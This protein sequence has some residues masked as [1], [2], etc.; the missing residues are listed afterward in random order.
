M[1]VMMRDRRLLTR[2]QVPI[3]L[4]PSAFFLITRLDGVSHHC[5]TGTMYI[6]RIAIQRRSGKQW[7][8]QVLHENAWDRQRKRPIQRYLGYI[9][10]NPEITLEKAKALARCLHVDLDDLRKVRG[11]MI[12]E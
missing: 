7:S 2:P 12:R 9:G 5:Y 1:K 6:T 10:T 3:K 8:Y 11:L 4:S